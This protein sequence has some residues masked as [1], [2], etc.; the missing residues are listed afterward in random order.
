MGE[1]VPNAVQ[2]ER[3]RRNELYRAWRKCVDELVP[4]GKWAP[5]WQRLRLLRPIRKEDDVFIIEFNRMHIDYL[6]HRTPELYA[7]L[8][9]RCRMVRRGDAQQEGA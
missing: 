4:G 2:P 7:E 5:G 1:T 9:K 3:Q 8:S 6:K